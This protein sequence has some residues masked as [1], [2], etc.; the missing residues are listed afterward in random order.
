MYFGKKVVS[1]PLLAQVLDYGDLGHQEVGQD[2]LAFGEP[3]PD[4]V[5]V[6]VEVALHTLWTAVHLVITTNSLQ[7]KDHK[8][9]V[10]PEVVF[11]LTEG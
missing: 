7:I 10:A 6:L 1:L 2:V 5:D 3:A 9:Q 4:V 8:K 11:V